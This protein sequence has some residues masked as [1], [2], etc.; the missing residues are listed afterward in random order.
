MKT[1]RALYWLIVIL[2]SSSLMLLIFD[3]ISMLRYSEKS[4]CFVAGVDGSPDNTWYYIYWVVTRFIQVLLNPVLAVIL[5][6]QPKVLLDTP[7]RRL[8]RV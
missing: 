1:I 7:D 2:G 5:F 6:W 3:V 8:Q 4:K